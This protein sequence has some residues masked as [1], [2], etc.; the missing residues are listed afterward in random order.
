[1]ATAGA[2]CHELNQP[3][4]AIM[5]LAEA[6]LEEIEPEHPV[7]QDLKDI[8]ENNKRLAAVTQKLTTITDYRTTRYS[9]ASDILDLEHSSKKDG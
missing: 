7:R 9:T 3:L 1:M 5:N 8:L 4:Q 2:A 6:A